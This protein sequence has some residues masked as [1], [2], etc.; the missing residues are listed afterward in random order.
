MPP[1]CISARRIRAATGS[2]NVVFSYDANPG[3]TRSGTLTIAGQTLTV[4]QAG[5]T[6]VIAQPLTTLVSSDLNLPSGVA[7]DGSG[8]VYIAD[9]DNNTIKIW[10]AANNTV[11]TL[12]SSNLS[13]PQSVAVDGSGNVYIADYGN[14]AIKVWTAANSNVTTLVSSE[15][16][17]P[18][19]VAVDGVGNVY[20]A[21][22]EMRS[23][24]GPQPTAT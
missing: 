13:Q 3:A 10:T 24:C 7:V 11:T 20:I 16:Y 9:T 18:T 15:L 17:E 14:N 12:V 22:T 5:S 4:T 19:G 6:Y 21:D 23:R 1:G 2:T 8:N